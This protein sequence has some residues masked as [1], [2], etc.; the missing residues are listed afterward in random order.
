MDSSRLRALID[1]PETIVKEEKLSQ[2]TGGTLD[3]PRKFV[4]PKY[5]INEKVLARWSDSRKFKA[6]VQ[7]ILPNGK[8]SLD[9]YFCVLL[10]TSIRVSFEDSFF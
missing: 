1:R 6:T 4:E 10:S 9:S 8:N 7:K 5:K 2:M 3:V